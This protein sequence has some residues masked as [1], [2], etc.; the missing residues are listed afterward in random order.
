[1]NINVTINTTFIA[2]L[3]VNAND[4]I[5]T[6]VKVQVSIFNCAAFSND[7]TE[8]NGL[9]VY[10][11]FSDRISEKG[12]SIIENFYYKNYRTCQNHLLC[13]IVIMYLQND[14][15]DTANGYRVELLNSDFSSLKN[16]SVLCAYG[17]TLVKSMQAALK[18]SSRCIIITNSRFYNNSGNPSL[19]S[20]SDLL[21]HISSLTLQCQKHNYIIILFGLMNVSSQE[22]Q[23]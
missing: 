19:I 10:V 2:I 8:I 15:R 12:S 14:K 3:I 16:S 20:Y 6:D 4:V 9:K 13:V 7:L 23:I 21:I 5:M 17:G 18:K 1:M 11:H 22:T